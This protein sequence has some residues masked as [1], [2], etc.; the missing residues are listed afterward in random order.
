VIAVIEALGATRIL[1]AVLRLRGM[2]L[3]QQQKRLDWAL[4]MPK[5][6][7]ACIDMTGIGL[8]LCEYAQE[9]FGAWRVR[10][11]NFSSSVPMSRRIAA[12]GR[13]EGERVRVTEHMATQLLERFEDRAIRIPIDTE[14]RED[15]RKPEKVVSPGGR[16]SIAAERD[17]SG[18]ADHFWAL[19]LAEEAAATGSMGPFQ[20]DRVTRSDVRA[21]GRGRFATAML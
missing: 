15:L 7:R 14:L 21:L 4:G 11:V 1:R 10:G 2:R 5:A 12:Q 19:A 13:R 18:H 16:V 3:P 6:K 20:A 8:G 9:K 17:G